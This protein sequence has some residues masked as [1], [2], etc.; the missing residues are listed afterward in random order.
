MNT[1]A[2]G[3]HETNSPFGMLATPTGETITI[4]TF[5]AGGGSEVATYQLTRS[6]GTRFEYLDYVCSPFV[7]FK[8]QQFFSKSLSILCLLSAL[9]TSPIPST[10][11]S[12]AT[13]F[14]M[15]PVSKILEIFG[16][17]LLERRLIVSAKNLGILSSCVNAL[18]SLLYPFSWQHVFIPVL[19][20]SL[21]DYCCAPMPFFVGVLTDSV[22]AIKKL[23]L[24]EVI[25]FALCSP[26]LMADHQTFVSLSALL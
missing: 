18:S 25:L 12:F 13:L 4:R 20:Q 10:Q 22:P 1:H 11:V 17:L 23:P 14:K 9:L 26:R 21:L 8:S 2:I 15:V 16:N 5:A 3:L 6:L 24:E 7:L 19:P